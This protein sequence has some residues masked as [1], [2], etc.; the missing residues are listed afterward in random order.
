[1]RDKVTWEDIYADFKRRFPKLSKLSVR[2]I[3]YGY[4]TILIYFSDGGK[5]I[6]D[7][8]R[9]IGQVVVRK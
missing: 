5:I 7:Y 9:Q 8:L 6:Y 1:M 3:P 4:L 2:Y